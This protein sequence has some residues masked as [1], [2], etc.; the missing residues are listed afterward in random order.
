LRQINTVKLI[1]SHVDLMRILGE[2][3]DAAIVEILALKPTLQEVEEAALWVTGNRDILAKDGH[4][5]GGVVAAIVE[6]MISDDEE[7]R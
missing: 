6:I 3:D 1:S 7:P 4:P 5:C 2:V